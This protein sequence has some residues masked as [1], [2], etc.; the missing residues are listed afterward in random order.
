M[1]D[2]APNYTFRYKLRYRGNGQTH[3]MLWRCPATATVAAIPAIVQNVEDFLGAIGSGNF[4]ADF[5]ILGA[6]YALADSD[7]FLPAEPLPVFAGSVNIDG[8]PESLQALALSFVGR[9]NIGQ[10]AAF[11]VYGT[12]FNAITSA[13]SLDFRLHPAENAN[14]GD[15]VNVLNASAGASMLVANDG[16]EVVWYPYANIKFNDYWVRQVRL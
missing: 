11:F 13:G 12:V 4:Y 16:V 2:F 8:R 9:S 5:A 1:P 6:S 10:R 3:H 7:V 15:A 14:I